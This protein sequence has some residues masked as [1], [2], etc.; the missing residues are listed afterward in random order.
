MDRESYTPYINPIKEINSRESDFAPAFVAGR[1]NEIIF[2][3]MRQAATGKRKSGITGQKYA[4]LFRATFNV[5]R[6]KVGPAKAA[7]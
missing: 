3:S 5:Q 7:R 2:T 4:D 1:D 6:Q